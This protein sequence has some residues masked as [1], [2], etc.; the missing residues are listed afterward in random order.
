MVSPSAPMVVET[1]GIPAAIASYTFRRVP[2]PMRSGT[3]DTE[4]PQRNGRISGT[5]PVT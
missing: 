5:V 1:T 2:P 3:I 4:D